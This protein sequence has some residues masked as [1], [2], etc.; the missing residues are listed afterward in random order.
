ML[1]EGLSFQSL[2]SKQIYSTAGLISYGAFEIISSH[3]TN[4]QWKTSPRLLLS[5]LEA[6]NR[7]FSFPK[8]LTRCTQWTGNRCILEIYSNILC[9]FT[10]NRELKYQLHVMQIL[11]KNSLKRVLSLWVYRLKSKIKI[12]TPKSSSDHN[13]IDWLYVTWFL[14]N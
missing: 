13:S 9:V 6:F 10:P 14:K 2:F 8:R 3:I 7:H 11:H 12:K 4:E 5:L 1:L